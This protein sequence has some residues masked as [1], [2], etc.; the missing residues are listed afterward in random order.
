MPI[1]TLEG[2]S[3][4]TAGSAAISTALPASETE[5]MPLSKDLRSAS[6]RFICGVPMKLATNTLAG[7]AKTSWGVPIC[8]IMPS[9]MMAMRS[10]MVS[11]SSWSWVTMTVALERLG[12]H[13]LDL[14]A[15]G[16]AQFDIEARQR[17]VEQEAIGIAHD[18]AGHGDALLFAFRNLARHAVEHFGE[19]QDLGHLVDALVATPP[20]RAFHNAA[21]WRCSRRR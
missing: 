6:I 10:A 12:Q 17:L 16:M 11:A 7:L 5:A 15:H 4:E 13:F 3:V 2:L 8:S 9:R 18:G 21:A 20:W 19:M 1:M 14:A